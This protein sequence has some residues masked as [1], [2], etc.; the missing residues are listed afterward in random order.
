MDLV[1]DLVAYNDSTLTL[2]SCK[3]ECME[4]SV[5]ALCNLKVVLGT[6]HGSELNAVSDN[7]SLLS[8]DG[9]GSVCFCCTV[10]DN[11]LL[12]DC[13]AL[14]VNLGSLVHHEH[15][16]LTCVSLGFV[17]VEDAAIFISGD[18]VGS[19]VMCGD[20]NR[21][22]CVGE[23]VA[24]SKV[25]LTNPNE[26]SAVDNLVEQDRLVRVSGGLENESRSLSCLV[27]GV[28]G[29]SCLSGNAFRNSRVCAVDNGN[30]GSSYRLIGNCSA[31]H[32]CEGNYHK[33][34]EH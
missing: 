16:E 25:T 31:C 14:K 30:V 17:H 11:Y 20:N 13:V 21:L 19:T 7:E 27:L 22:T 8:N 9:R 33:C 5:S 32:N 2:I 24:V 12:E 29:A 10:E 18:V 4:V 3:A 15:T 28:C 26:L 6:L 1:L 34:Y 23:G